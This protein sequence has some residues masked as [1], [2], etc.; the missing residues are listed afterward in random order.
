MKWSLID[1]DSDLLL[2][3]CAEIDG[4]FLESE[5]IPPP[6]RYCLLGCE[7]AGSPRPGAWLSTLGLHPVH[8][9]GANCGCGL[10]IGCFCSQELIDV[11][12]LGWCPSDEWPGLVD[13]DLRG[14]VRIAPEEVPEN[15]GFLLT[16]RND[17]RLGTC[18]SVGGVY[19]E[20]PE[21]LVRPATLVGCRPEAPLTAAIEATSARRRRVAAIIQAVDGAG[22]ETGIGSGVFG[23][24]TGVR[25]SRLGDGLLDITL[26][27]GVCDPLPS[28]AREIWQTWYDGR[29][30]RRNLWTRYDRALRH[31][32]AGAALSH[33]AGEDRPAGS[34]Y[35]FD[36]GAVTDIEGFYC[37]LG[38]A[39]N[40]PGGYFGWNLDA[41]NDCLRGRW[42]AS[43]PFR[44]V[45]HDADVAR[46]HLVPGYD[47]SPY[48]LRKWGEAVTL[49]YLLGMFAASGV[50]VDLSASPLDG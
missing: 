4:L 33:H 3:V 31:E 40:G 50:Q 43:S 20:R 42:G 37:A 11:T 19:R 28:G 30:T 23:A 32:W 44:L 12:V 9:P 27:D 39:I 26:N 24:I 49:E 7:P 36:G 22:G 16:G 21:P 45:W 41:L 14:Y 1:T 5:P 48:D 10:E 13:I 2:G 15:D 18:R 38:E 8:G 25:P 46:R 17:E 47:R 35:H 29:P 34:T 6:E